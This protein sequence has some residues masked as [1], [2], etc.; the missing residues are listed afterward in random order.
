MTFR[1]GLFPLIIVAALGWLAVSTLGD[2][3]S[4]KER[5]TF[6][7]VLNQVRQQPRAIQSVLFHPST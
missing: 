1:K 5:V 6:S 3:D 4:K 2:A 7:Q